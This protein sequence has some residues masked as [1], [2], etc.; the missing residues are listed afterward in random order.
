[1][2]QK[3]RRCVFLGADFNTFSTDALSRGAVSTQHTCYFAVNYTGVRITIEAR[4]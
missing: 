1:M 4:V 3:K 2:G